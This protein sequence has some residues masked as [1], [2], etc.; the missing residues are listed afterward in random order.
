MKTTIKIGTL[1]IAFTL[2]IAACKKKE[3]EPEPEPAA[4]LA[5]APQMNGSMTAML[6]GASWTSIKN[7]A[8]L[9]VD[10]DQDL[11]ALAI[12][13]ETSGDMFVMGI[14]FPTSNTTFATGNYDFGG[15]NDQ[16]LLLYATKTS[17]GTTTQHFPKSG[18]INITSVD[19][20][21]K[22]ISGTFDF[23][24]AK[25]GAKTKADSIFI[26]NGVFTNIT[27]VIGTK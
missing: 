24:L 3:D 17:G 16:A 21:N 22:K 7:S 1:L 26:T 8:S 6:N 27:Y 12:N 15:A 25:S 5:P 23:I 4:A 18:N 20:T 19:H 10:N 9:V 13:G 14:D 11:S 2:L